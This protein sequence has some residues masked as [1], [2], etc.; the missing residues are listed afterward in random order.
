MIRRL[1]ISVVEYNDDGTDGKIDNVDV[2]LQVRVTGFRS[3]PA[4]VG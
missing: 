4:G 1:V 2:V 3:V